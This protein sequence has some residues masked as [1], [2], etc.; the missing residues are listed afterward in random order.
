MK[1]EKL[2]PDDYKIK[3]YDMVDYIVMGNTT[4]ICYRSHRNTQPTVAKLNKESYL[5]YSTGEVKE[6]QKKAENRAESPE[7]LRKTFRKIG[8]LINTNI[9]DVK[10]IKFITFTYAENVRSA[11]RLYDDFRKFNMR[12]IDYCVSDNYGKPE[13]IS[14]A[15]PQG[16]GAWHLHVFYIFPR[17]ARYIPHQLIAALWPHGYIYIKN[18]NNANNIAGYVNAYLANMEI[19]ETAALA[20]DESNVYTAEIEHQKKY[21][22]KGARLPY[23][24]AGFNIL[25][26][27]KGL[28][29]PEKYVTTYEHACELIRDKEQTL[30]YKSCS[31]L[32]GE[33]DYELIIKKEE[34]RK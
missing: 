15:E 25:R 2:S 6:Y 1:Y 33:G 34:Y 16:R 17:P 27:S 18:L 4:E 5:V 12:F 23:Y 11:Q 10:N 32:N 14:I 28:K 22:L 31:K 30:K 24:P 19:P 3:P 29:K 9:T 20:L 7:S 13:Y 26:H 21:F 8:Q